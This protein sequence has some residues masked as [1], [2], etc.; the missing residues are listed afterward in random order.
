MTTNYGLQFRV[1]SPEQI[2]EFSGY[3]RVVAQCQIANCG[4]I[5]ADINEDII[6]NEFDLE[7]IYSILDK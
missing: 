4:H 5:I 2:E 6:D 7:E 1:L 3:D